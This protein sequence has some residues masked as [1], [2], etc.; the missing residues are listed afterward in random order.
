[1]K[2]Y[3]FGSVVSNG[4]V[5]RRK[6]NGTLIRLTLHSLFS[7]EIFKQGYLLFHLQVSNTSHMYVSGP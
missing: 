6:T 4:L 1:M 5:N 7:I 2:I 3:P